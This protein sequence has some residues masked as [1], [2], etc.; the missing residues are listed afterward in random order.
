M[1][2]QLRRTPLHAAH[3]RH[4]G[5][6]VPFAGWEMPV[7]YS[8]INDECRA[9][10]QAAG[11]F[12]VSHMGRLALKGPQSL[13]L[14]QY[15]LPRDLA[16]LQAQRLCYSVL[17]DEQ[18]RAVD[19][20]IVC[21]LGQGDFLLVVN[22]S[23]LEADLDWISG[24]AGHFPRTAIEDQ[25]AATAMLALQGPRAAELMLR[26]GCAAAGELDYLE[27]RYAAL[28][29]EEALC[30]RSGYTGEDGFEIICPAARAESL[31]EAFLREG[32]K[33]CGLGARDVLRTEMGYCLYGHELS[34]QITPLEAG[35]S[36]AL[37]LDK[38]AD[39][40]GKGALQRLRQQGGYPRLVGLA[41]LEQGI[42][43]PGFAVCDDRG[44]QVGTISS[45]TYSPALQQGIALAFV[46]PRC[47]RPGTQLQIDLRGR[48]RPARVVRLPFV[49]ARLKRR[50]TDNG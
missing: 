25:S 8:G 3:L 13:D 21:C 47:R 33:P 15:L 44:E 17:C 34:E 42:P 29:G 22:A 40:I 31:W 41:L 20:L 24:A 6:L 36:W 32:A 43:R 30:S 14:L 9:V 39:F 1:N 27:C 50:G 18:G 23:R 45:G 12:D 37:S 5:R 26:L 38:E 11:L 7:Q 4:G 2:P 46:A 10:R 49:P 35:L 19:D 16:R 28:A 48:S